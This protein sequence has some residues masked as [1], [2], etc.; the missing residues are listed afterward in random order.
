MPHLAKNVHCKKLVIE[1][2]LNTKSATSIACL[3]NKRRGKSNT[4]FTRMHG[5]G[6]LHFDQ[7]ELC[8]QLDQNKQ[9]WIFKNQID[10]VVNL[11]E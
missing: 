8:L 10:V 2:S 3:W 7:S 11:N 6:T 1:S 5:A 4:I 9:A